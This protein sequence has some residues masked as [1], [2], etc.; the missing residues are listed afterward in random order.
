MYWLPSNT[1][2]MRW[3]PWQ[4]KLA[5]FSI[6]IGWGFPEQYQRS[7][8]ENGEPVFHHLYTRQLLRI[9]G[10]NYLHIQTE[11]IE[12]E[13]C[14]PLSANGTNTGAIKRERFYVYI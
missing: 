9:P 3:E 7:T 14:V 13:S 10:Y 5:S 12:A 11:L 6:L 1:L 2:G 4:M 8:S